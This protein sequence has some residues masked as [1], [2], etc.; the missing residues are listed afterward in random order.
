MWQLFWK[1]EASA[2]HYDNDGSTLEV[3]WRR[4][5]ASRIVACRIPSSGLGMM[6]EKK[7]LILSDRPRV[8]SRI[9][10]RLGVLWCCGVVVLGCVI[11]ATATTSVSGVLCCVVL[12]CVIVAT[13][14][15][16]VCR[17]DDTPCDDD[18][19]DDGGDDEVEEEESPLPFDDIPRRTRARVGH[20]GGAQLHYITLH[21]IALHCI[22]LHHTALHYMSRTRRSPITL[23][24]I[25][26]H[27]I[28]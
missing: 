19:D 11:V 28:T 10:M 20:I 18:D 1:A 22:A 9:G 16:R 25:T 12:C 14:R 15:R 2:G 21:C 8:V 24:Y 13:R 7:T 4:V 3:W 27:Y 17:C 5:V 26:L 23:H 6:R